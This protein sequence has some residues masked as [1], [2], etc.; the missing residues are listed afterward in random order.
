MRATAV[1][2]VHRHMRWA[3]PVDCEQGR[4]SGCIQKAAQELNVVAQCCAAIGL[5]SGHE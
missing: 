3:A 4:A 2:S 1:L 5:G